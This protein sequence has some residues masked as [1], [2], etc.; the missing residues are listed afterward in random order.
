[1]TSQTPTDQVQWVVDLETIKM[2]MSKYC[3]GID[4]QNE[5]LFMSI[6][7]DDA[8]YVLPR[9][10][11]HGIEGVRALVRKVWTQVPR[12]HHHI[13]NPIIDIDGD[14]A[15]ARTDVFYFRLT[16]DG[17]NQLLS[18]GY[19]LE[20]VRQHG[21]WKIRRMEFSPFVSTSPVFA[22]NQGPRA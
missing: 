19:D 20:F 12:C 16:D 22:E 13:T 18:G 6:W 1:M 4:K 17:V 11:G 15:T 9:G 10:E 7:S 21:D 3:H 5:E 8:D 14:T 2:L